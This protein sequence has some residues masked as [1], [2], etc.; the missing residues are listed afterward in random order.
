MK[1]KTPARVSHKERLLSAIFSG[2]EDGISVLDT[3]MNISTVNPAMERWYAHAMP[4]EGKKC[5]EAYHLRSSACENCPALRTIKRGEAAQQVVPRCGPAGETVGWLELFTFPM[6]DKTTGKL[7]GVIEYVHDITGRKTAENAIESAILRLV[8][9]V[10]RV[11]EGV[12]L[13]DDKGHFH[14]YNAK[15]GDITGYTMQEANSQENFIDLI[16][17]DPGE[18]R[19]ALER[20]GEAVEQGGVH[21]AEMVIRAKSGAVKTILVS[22]S[23]MYPREGRMFLSVYRDI[24]A[25]KDTE[26]LKDDFIAMVSHELRTPLS[27]VKEGVSLVLD[28]IPGEINGMQAKVLESAKSNI[29]RL[30]RII[31]NLL[32]ISKM[33]SG[34]FEAKKKLIDLADTARQVTGFFGKKAAEKSLPIELKLSDPG[35]MLHADADMMTQALSNIIDN[36]VKFTSSGQITVEL[37]QSRYD[38]ECSV[39]DTGIGIAKEDMPKLFGKF[40]QFGRSPGP[41]EKGTGLGLSIAKR[42][43][44]MHGGRIWA[45][46][47]LG[48]GTRIKFTIPKEA[49]GPA[50]EAGHGR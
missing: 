28:G 40:Q 16:C 35:M 34:K 1:K 9:V 29:D 41:G 20:I 46:S 42:I 6:T 25:L 48:G 8:S 22:T 37:K 24:T 27:I 23:I 38:I 17:P 12:T 4:L 50:G 39:S 31:N 7:V 33:E 11:D 3:K 36:A 49:G 32:D 14:I 44:E 2:I 26:K 43:I 5:Y 19:K 21:E 45:E 10:E 15:M 47:L 18:R 30:A 13:S